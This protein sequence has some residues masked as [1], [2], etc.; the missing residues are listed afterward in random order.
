[1]GWRGDEDHWLSSKLKQAKRNEVAGVGQEIK[2]PE[3]LLKSKP[4]ILIIPTQWR[5]RDILIEIDPIGLS[6]EQV[7]IEHNGRLIDFREEEH[8]YAK[9]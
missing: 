3:E 6:F 9:R 4:D 8:P 1:M 5:A 7:L 2:S